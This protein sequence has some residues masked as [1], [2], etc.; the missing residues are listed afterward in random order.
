VIRQ[1]GGWSVVIVR[2]IFLKFVIVRCILVIVKCIL[3][4]VIVIFV[5]F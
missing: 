2:C 5:I 3:V 4:I 1:S